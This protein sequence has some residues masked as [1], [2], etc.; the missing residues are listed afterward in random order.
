MIIAKTVHQT[1]NIVQQSSLCLFRIWEYEKNRSSYLGDRG[2]GFE[3]CR[4]LA[5][6]GFTVLFTVRDPNRGNI[7][8]NEL[9]DKEGLY[10]IRIKLDLDIFVVQHS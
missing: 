5:K 8:A 3:A 6:S 7:A 9:T 10:V 4:Q 1:F 2:A